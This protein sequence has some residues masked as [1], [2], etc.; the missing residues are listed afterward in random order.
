MA[1]FLSP[2][3]TTRRRPRRQ[4]N[5]PSLPPPRTPPRT[6]P[7]AP[8]QDRSPPN[9]TTRRGRHRRRI[10]DDDVDFPLLQV[11]ANTDDNNVA[12]EVHE[13]YEAFEERLP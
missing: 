13:F 12:Y 8:L 6:P 2:N 5:E 4:I 7:R 1:D 10:E 9:V 3:V 11:F